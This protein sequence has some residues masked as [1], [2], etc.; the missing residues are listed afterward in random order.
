[1]PA[2]FGG[3]TA[4]VNFSKLEAQFSM[5]R[6]VYGGIK[7]YTEDAQGTLQGG[8]HFA[9]APIN[10]NST[11]WEFPAGT[12]SAIIGIMETLPG[13][14]NVT[15]QDLLQGEVIIP[16]RPTD[17]NAYTYKDIL[18]VPNGN[19]GWASSSQLGQAFSNP[20]WY[21]IL[22]FATG[23]LTSATITVNRVVGLE[24][25]PIMGGG[26][27]SLMETTPA[28]PYNPI[29]LSR[30]TIVAEQMPT[31]QIVND[32]TQAERSWE[33]FFSQAWDTA[34]RVGSDVASGVG[35]VLNAVGGVTLS[36]A[37]VTLGGSSR[38]R[39]TNG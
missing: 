28:A 34:C 30:S 6:P 37:G 23:T 26:T 4:P 8:V 31:V 10:L 19:Q 17:M 13:Y 5:V 22:M 1:M 36:P 33:G 21:A 16:F 15:A 25:L 38:R 18:N 12:N 35:N 9:L 20:G 29:E 2:T 39:L 11:T 32:T 27:A 14:V 7:V 3:T 24:C